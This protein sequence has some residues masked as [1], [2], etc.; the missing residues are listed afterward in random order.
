MIENCA[1]CDVLLHEGLHPARLRREQARLAEV[2]TNFHTS[3]K[4]LAELATKAKPEKVLV[5]YHQM[6]FGGEKDTEEGM[7]KEIHGSYTGKVVSAH[8]L[9]G[10]ERAAFT[11]RSSSRSGIAAPTKDLR[12]AAGFRSISRMVLSGNEE[13]ALRLGAAL[14]VG[15]LFGLNRELHGKPAG[16][17]T[18]PWSVAAPPAA[19]ILSSSARHLDGRRP[20]PIGRVVQGILTGVGF[21]GAGVI[22]RDPAGHVTGL[23]TA[24]TIWM[25]AV[26]GIV[27]GSA[28]WVLGIAAG[29]TAITLL[30]GRPLE[31]LAERLFHR[32]ASNPPDHS[33]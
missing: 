15:S 16:L 6:F 23:T 31:R 33:V 8:D 24:A 20:E 7:L 13:T 32:H 26:L 10:Q 19:P 18:T 22:L 1:G 27:C 28:C 5:L 4:E 17:R 3:T 2:F 25:C 9:G 12:S 21:L 14:L 11:D 30:L 29:L